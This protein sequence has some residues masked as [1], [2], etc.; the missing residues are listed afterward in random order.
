MADYTAVRL[1]PD[2]TCADLWPEGRFPR[3][4]M[5]VYK[6]LQERGEIRIQKVIYHRCQHLVTVMYLSTL[7]HSFVLESMRKEYRNEHRSAEP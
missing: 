6:R 1:T 2:I 7:P 3:E 5:E 4:K